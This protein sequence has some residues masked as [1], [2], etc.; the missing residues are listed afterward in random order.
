VAPPDF[1]RS[2]TASTDKDYEIGNVLW[3][4]NFNANPDVACWIVV[5]KNADGTAKLKAVKMSDI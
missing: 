4:N 3:N 1:Y 2:S 5:S